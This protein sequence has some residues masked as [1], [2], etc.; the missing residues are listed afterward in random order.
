MIE[1]IKGKALA[2]G[3]LE[4]ERPWGTRVDSDGQEGLTHSP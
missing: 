4:D 1:E 2:D 3:R